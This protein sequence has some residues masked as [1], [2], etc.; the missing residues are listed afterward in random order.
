L[1]GLPPVASLGPPGFGGQGVAAVADSKGAGA[2]R[3]DLGQGL[4]DL[5]RTWSDHA[6]LR[7]AARALEEDD[8]STAARALRTLADR[9]PELSEAGARDLAEALQE[10]AESLGAS[11]GTQELD[12]ALREASAAMEREPALEQSA[13]LERLAQAIELEAGAPSGAPGGGRGQARERDGPPAARLEV[14]SRDMPVSSDSPQ[15]GAVAAAR[16]AAARGAAEAGDDAVP[17]DRAAATSGEG[18]MGMRDGIVGDAL[19][20][21]VR[22]RLSAFERDITSRYFLRGRGSSPALSS[23]DRDKP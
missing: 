15:G 9:A 5:A 3:A 18:S 21:A 8:A 19:A 2:A 1:R 12:A 16:S 10:A 7:P 17:V 23:P 4:A 14:P 13:A 20:P 6:A 22:A 11:G